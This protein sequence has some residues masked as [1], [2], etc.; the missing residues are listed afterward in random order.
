MTVRN[1]RFFDNLVLA[2]KGEVVD[3]HVHIDRTGPDYA[4]G[5]A[6]RKAGEPRD[7]AQSLNWILGWDEAI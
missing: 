4:N 3:T 1:E 2:S 7:P 6:A 5:K